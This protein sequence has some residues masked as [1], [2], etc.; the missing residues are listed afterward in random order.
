MNTITQIY[1]EHASMPPH[2]GMKR[3]KRAESG[4]VLVRES[5]N[6][7]NYLLHD[8]ANMLSVSRA[9]DHKFISSPDAFFFPSTVSGQGGKSL[10]S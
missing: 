5:E 6:L 10:R 2:D 8:A 4:A 3:K 9:S 7:I 1:E